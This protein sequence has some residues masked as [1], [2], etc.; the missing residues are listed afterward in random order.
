M[1]QFTISQLQQKDTD[2]ALLDTDLLIT[3][4]GTNTHDL[5]SIQISLYQYAQFLF[6]AYATKYGISIAGNT[7]MTGGL[8]ADGAAT[9]TINITNLQITA[10][11]KTG[12][13]Y[14]QTATQIT[15][16]GS[17]KVVCVK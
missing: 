2:Y 15:T 5:S 14:T 6:N 10:P 13:L 16:G 12:D 1:A 4:I 3:S 11:P 8:S 9:N 7:S 17:T